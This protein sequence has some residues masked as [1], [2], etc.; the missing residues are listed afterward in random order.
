MSKYLSFTEFLKSKFEFIESVRVA[1]QNNILSIILVFSRRRRDDKK[2]IED[3]NNIRIASQLY[4]SNLDINNYHVIFHCSD[5]LTNLVWFV[6]KEQL[7]NYVTEM[8]TWD[9]LHKDLIVVEIGKPH[10]NTI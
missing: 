7:I 10:V 2:L 5:T 8:M 3:I 4:D 1:N 9:E 6:S